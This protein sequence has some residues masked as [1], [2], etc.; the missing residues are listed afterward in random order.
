MGICI[1]SSSKCNTFCD[2]P[3]VSSVTHLKWSSYSSGISYLFLVDI[4]FVIT[5]IVKCFTDYLSC[6][7]KHKASTQFNID[8]HNFS[9]WEVAVFSSWEVAMFSSWEVAVFSSW[10]VAMISSCESQKFQ[11]PIQCFFFFPQTSVSNLFVTDDA[12]WNVYKYPFNCW[13]C[14]SISGYTCPCYLKYFPL[15]LYDR[16]N[17]FLHCGHRRLGRKLQIQKYYNLI[18]G[19]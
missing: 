7:N 12:C 16:R 17:Q 1:L 10:E 14:A 2:W 3:T 18:L 4:K 9:S 15:H 13:P 11:F 8:G 19:K 5:K 6:S